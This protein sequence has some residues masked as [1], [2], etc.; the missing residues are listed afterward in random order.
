MELPSPGEVLWT[1]KARGP[2]ACKPAVNEVDGT[3]IAHVY[4]HATTTS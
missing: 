1:F 2:I 3:G 4:V